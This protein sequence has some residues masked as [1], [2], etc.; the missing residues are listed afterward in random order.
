MDNAA[1][2]QAGESDLIRRALEGSE[3]AWEALMCAHQEPV[4]RFAYLL[5]GDAD[6]AADAAQETFIRAYRALERFDLDRPLRPWLLAIAAN[7][8]RNRRRSLGRYLAAVQRLG[9]RQEAPPGNHPI[10]ELSAERLQAQLLWQAVRRLDPDAQQLLYLRFFLDLS[11]E[12]TAQVL[13]VAPGTVK[14]RSH[15]AVA[16]LRGIIEREYPGLLPEAGLVTMK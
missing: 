10:E 16:R 7:L 3:A 8:A 5:L 1:A 4:F 14:S 9:R 15:R 13:G 11:I 12:E 6:E 2:G